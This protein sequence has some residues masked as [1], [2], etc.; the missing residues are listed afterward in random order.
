MALAKAG[1]V[2]SLEQ[3]LK[4]VP[5]PEETRA[6]GKP[7]GIAFYEIRFK[8]F[9]ADDPRGNPGFTSDVQEYHVHGGMT[10][11]DALCHDSSDG[12]L[13][14]GFALADT[15]NAALSANSGPINVT[16]L[17]TMT[18]TS[19]VDTVQFRQTVVL[20]AD[21]ASAAGTPTGTVT[22]SDGVTILGS[23]PLSAGAASLPVVVGPVGRNTLT[24]IYSGDANFAP[25]S[26]S[27]VIYR[28]PKPH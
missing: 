22:F 15:V 18:L 11:L 13:Y 9:P 6:D 5:K 2:V 4:V 8:T 17:T 24:A 12:R 25:S 28:S 21:V 19:S 1:V 27:L 7:H 10:H 14:N 3:P 23:A 20:T 26:A 16:T